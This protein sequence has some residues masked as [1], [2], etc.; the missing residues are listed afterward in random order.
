[1]FFRCWSLVFAVPAADARSKRWRG[2]YTGRANTEGLKS[3]LARLRQRTSG[4]SHETNTAEPTHHHAHVSIRSD[5]KQYIIRVQH[6]EGYKTSVWWRAVV[7]VF[8]EHNNISIVVWRAARKTVNQNTIFKKLTTNVADEIYFI[9]RKVLN[10]PRKIVDFNIN[11]IFLSNFRSNRLET[12][13]K[14]D[15]LKWA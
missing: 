15:G 11:L 4:Q 5:M 1:M 8:P 9:A 13:Q 12:F 3:A 6:A 7:D 2:L 14:T 10:R